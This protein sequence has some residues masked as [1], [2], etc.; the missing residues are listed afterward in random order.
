MVAVKARMR[1]QPS[2]AALA[3]AINAIEDRIKVA[4]PQVRWIFFE[5]DVR[6]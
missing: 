1:D 6:D 5:P 3:E 2:S 4:F